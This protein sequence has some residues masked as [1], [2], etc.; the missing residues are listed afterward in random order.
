[1]NEWRRSVPSDAAQLPVLTQFLQEFWSAVSLPS[2]QA[3]SFELA[4]EEIFMNVVMHSSSV[5]GA[6]HIE[7]SLV[8]AGGAV[9]L[10]IEDDGAEFDPL[11]LPQPNL[12]ASL[13]ERPI[14]GL[15]V[16]LVRQ[17][18]DTVSYQR[19]GATNRLRMSKHVERLR[20]GTSQGATGPIAK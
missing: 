2:A 4:L 5:T 13:G 15:G 16:F 3:M 1:V 18:M 19:L 12:E 17:L 6:P 14:G 20:E 8:L 10:T 11:T 7:V 9:V